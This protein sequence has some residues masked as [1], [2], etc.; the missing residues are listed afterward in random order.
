[1]LRDRLLAGNHHHGGGHYSR[2]GVP[3]ARAP[4]E[5]S[6]GEPGRKEVVSGCLISYP[7]PVRPGISH[8]AGFSTRERNS[9]GTEVGR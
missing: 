4:A 8:S 1:M 5:R 6:S 3:T 9:E 2:F 7:R